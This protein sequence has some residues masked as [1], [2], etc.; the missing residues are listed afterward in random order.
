MG[1]FLYTS[2]TSIVCARKSETYWNRPVSGRQ[3]G[4]IFLQIFFLG[5]FLEAGSDAV[6]YK[7]KRDCGANRR[8]PPFAPP[9]FLT[10]PWPSWW[11]GGAFGVR[12]VTRRGCL[13]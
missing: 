7:R 13:G 6:A 4:G 1:V 5:N 10:H 9:S 2:T 8:R 3:N 12:C 11:L